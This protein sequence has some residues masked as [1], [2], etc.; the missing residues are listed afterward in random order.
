MAAKV[1]K[2]SGT[3]IESS[4]SFN[5]VVEIG[6]RCRIGSNVVIGQPSIYDL[7]EVHKD[8]GEES[9]H[10]HSKTVIGDDVIIQ[11]NVMISNGVRI[12]NHVKIDSFVLIDKNAKVGAH[13]RIMY[14]SQVHEEVQI[15]RD[16]KIGGFLCDCS[17]IGDRVTVMGSLL[18]PYR[19]GWD[20]E[21]D[22]EDL[23]YQSPIIDNDVIIGYGSLVI[24]KVRVRS[25]TFIAAGAIVTKDTSGWCVIKGVDGSTP[26][27][28]Y[29]GPLKEGK[30][31]RGWDLR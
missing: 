17:H 2:G 16:C 14:N 31:F 22:L 9:E 29:S 12:G 26:I 24:G 27:G 20:E 4:V 6:N 11:P 19:D 10:Q 13:T 5:G 15:G 30:F 3:F 25:K 7:E 23:V 1:T 21:Q 18:H 8:I 28:C